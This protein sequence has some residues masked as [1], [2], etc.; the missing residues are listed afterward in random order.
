MRT[1]RAR[2]PASDVAPA[3][4][5]AAELPWVE[6]SAARL[7]RDLRRAGYSVVGDLA[8]LAPRTDRPAPAGAPVA[9]QQVLDLAIGMLVDP[10]WRT[11]VRTREGRAER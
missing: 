3:A 2:M 10:S 4:V 1:L 11:T 8:D 5:P 6:A 9:D 7:T